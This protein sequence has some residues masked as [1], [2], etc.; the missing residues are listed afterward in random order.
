MK[1]LF[2]INEDEKKRIL[3]LHESATKNQYLINEVGYGTGNWVDV[4]YKGQTLTLNNYLEMENRQGGDELKLNKGVVFTVKDSNTLIAK[5][6]PFQ[7]VG[8]YTG[9]VSE[10][11]KADVEYYCGKKEFK[12]IGRELTYWGEDFQS[13]VQKAF[14]DLCGEASTATPAASK[15]GEE[16]F[17]NFPCVP[18]LA[19]KKGVEMEPNNSFVIGN[20]RY[21]GN[22]R[23]GDT[24]TK[25]MLNYTCNDPEF[26]DTSEPAK[27][28]TVKQSTPK[29]SVPSDADLDKYLNS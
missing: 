9:S 11:G 15:S 26:K 27:K 10:N 18:T 20:F 22:G 8:D 25:Q 2:L 14:D 29:Q 13:D 7:I 1:N 23:K 24:T 12:I 5:N 28:S 19:N 17:K 21:F 4:N 6:T 3:N 16:A